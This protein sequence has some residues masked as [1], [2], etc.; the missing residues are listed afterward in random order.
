MHYLVT[1]ALVIGAFI[2]LAFF[3]DSASVR[4]ENARHTIA[5]NRLEE[6]QR[7]EELRHTIASNQQTEQER[8]AAAAYRGELAMAAQPYA[9]LLIRV[10][11]LALVLVVVLVVVVVVRAVFA[12]RQPPPMAYHV[13]HLNQPVQA[14]RRL[15]RARLLSDKQPVEWGDS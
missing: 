3:L 2:G 13:Y 10:I 14:P 8:A 12:P 11:L 15:S 1:I 6:Q 5:S 7:A 4:S 9:I